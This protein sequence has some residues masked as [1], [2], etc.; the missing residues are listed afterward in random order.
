VCRVKQS[1]N[2]S[3]HTEKLRQC[4]FEIGTLYVTTPQPS[5]YFVGDKW[6]F[7]YNCLNHV[8]LDMALKTVVRACIVFCFYTNLSYV[9]DQLWLWQVIWCTFC[10][11]LYYIKLVFLRSR[12]VSSWVTN[13]HARSSSSI[14]LSYMFS[15]SSYAVLFLVRSMLL[16][17]AYLSTVWMHFWAAS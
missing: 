5:R 15:S 4:H 1:R 2:I 3:Q 8:K 17:S 10:V 9:T 13:W 6:L 7:E 11:V 14:P 16:L 12:V